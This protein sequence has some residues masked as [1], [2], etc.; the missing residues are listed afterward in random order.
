MVKEDA[1]KKIKESEIH[2]EVE[3][4]ERIDP[5]VKESTRTPKQER[6]NELKKDD[7]V[8][9]MDDLVTE[10]APASTQES[11]DIKSVQEAKEKDDTT[12]KFLYSFW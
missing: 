10:D 11:T 4:D 2:K 7:I 6:F 3:T 1:V 8:T 12:Q 9:T 5:S